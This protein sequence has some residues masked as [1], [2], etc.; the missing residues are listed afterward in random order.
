MIAAMAIPL[1]RT[2]PRLLPPSLPYE[3]RPLPPRRTSFDYS[4]SSWTKR[5]LNQILSKCCTA[6]TVAGPL[7]GAFSSFSGGGGRITAL[8]FPLPAVPASQ[9]GQHLIADG[10]APPGN[11]VDRDAVAD[12]RCVGAAPHLSLRQAGNIERHQVHG[13]ATCQEAA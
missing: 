6:D 1:A 11:V 3:S 5:G 12:Q 13:N 10:A 4:L 2:W 8:S 7:P 9:P